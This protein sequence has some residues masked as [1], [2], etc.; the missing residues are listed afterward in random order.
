MYA[1]RRRPV[2]PSWTDDPVRDANAYDR[3]QE[4]L[5]QWYDRHPDSEDDE[6]EYECA[7]ADSYYD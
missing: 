6:Y 2:S 4:E 7:R 1:V 5:R 3:Y